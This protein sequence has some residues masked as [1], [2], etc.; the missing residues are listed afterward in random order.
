MV[1]ARTCFSPPVWFRRFALALA[2]ALAAGSAAAPARA[3]TPVSIELVLAVD[4]SVSVNDSE[5]LLQMAGI[6]TALRRPEVRRLITDHADGVALTV[7]QWAGTAAVQQVVPWRLLRT[8]Q[9]V[10]RFAMEVERARR[11]PL[12]YYTAP[13]HA[14]LGAML[15]LERNEYA[16]YERK[17]DIS[18]DGRR[19]TGPPPSEARAL[20]NA[21]GVTIN[22]LA[23]LKDDAGLAW[24]YEREIAGGPGSFV[25][26]AD[27]FEDFADAMARKLFREL[28]PRMSRREAPPHAYAGR[29]NARSS[30]VSGMRQE[31]PRGVS[32]YSGHGN[33]SGGS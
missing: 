19:N 9:D 4:C 8:E 3:A 26:S 7:M 10:A 13:G 2:F 1:P 14:I 11:A 30:A 5:Y 20:A 16:G 17:I 21:A 31:R 12:S 6:A 22:G 27:T 32:M 15:L 18:G 29:A 25:V 24:Y 28:S 33:S 23:I